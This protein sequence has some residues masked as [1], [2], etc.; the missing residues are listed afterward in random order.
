MFVGWNM[1]IL[2][3]ILEQAKELFEAIVNAIFF[4]FLNKPYC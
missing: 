2:G 1:E 4:E 3:Q